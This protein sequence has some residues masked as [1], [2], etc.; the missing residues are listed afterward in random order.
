MAILD[1]AL[2]AVRSLASERGLN[3]SIYVRHDGRVGFVFEDFDRHVRHAVMADLEP[4]SAHP[5]P[6]AALAASPIPERSKR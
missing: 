1:E 4:G 3:C 5:L 6:S 2:A